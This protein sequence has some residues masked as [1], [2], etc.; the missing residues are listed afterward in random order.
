MNRAVLPQTPSTLHPELKRLLPELAKFE[1]TGLLEDSDSYRSVRDHI[2]N[3]LGK[4]WQQDLASPSEISNG[5]IKAVA[6]NIE[7]GLRLDAIIANLKNHPSLRSADLLL[8]SELD[9][10]M[11]RSGNRFVAQEIATV[12]GLNFAFAPCYIPLSKGAGVE[13][14]SEGTNTDSLHGIGLFSRYPMHSV[15]TV[16]LP[17][18][19]DKMKG[20][21][22][23]LGSLRALIADIDHPA[24]EF[25]AVSLHLDALSSQAHRLKQM[26]IVLNHLSGLRPPLPTLIGGDWNTSTHDASRAVYAILGYCRRV[27]MGIRRVIRNHYPHPERWFERR[28]FRE[29]ESRGYN[30]RDLN[31]PGECTLHYNLADIVTNLNMGEWLPQWCFWFIHWALQRAGG[32]CSL[33]LDWFA[34]KD[35]VRS[36][37]MKAVPGL[38]DSS[39]AAVSDHDPIVLSFRPRL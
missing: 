38:R 14:D 4:V 36:G 35:I 20:A 23:R 18:G 15:H 37:E 17:N 6:W 28:L 29:L 9:W 19:K 1:S 5:P 2:E 8:L 26:Q 7:R 25:R 31:N 16:S 33:K 13:K 22:K 39:G 12:L 21:E 10:G 34:G 32:N 11:A 24:G 30:Y 3:V 27:M